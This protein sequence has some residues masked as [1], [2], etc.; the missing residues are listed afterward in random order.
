MSLKAFLGGKKCFLTGFGKSLAMAPQGDTDSHGA[1]V[2]SLTARYPGLLL[3]AKLAVANLI[4][5]FKCDTWFMQS[6]SKMLPVQSHRDA[7]DK[8]E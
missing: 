8:C 4:G 2:A 3:V 1:N 6:P 5:P 7:Q